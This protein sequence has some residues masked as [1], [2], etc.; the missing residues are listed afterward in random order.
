[1][2][3]GAEVILFIFA[4]IVIAAI[5]W[6][7]NTFGLDWATSATLVRN[8]VI[9]IGIIGS[10]NYF[11]LFKI[12]PHAPTALVGYL[13]C[14]RPAL[15]YWS[16]SQMQN[17]GMFNAEVAWYANGWIQLGVATSI[18]VLGY[19]FIYWINRSRIWY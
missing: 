14:W 18:I 10:L 17:F 7:H 9:F 12:I 19:S 6:F 2:N 11:D 16:N 13:A 4:V 3:Q 8:H 15:E 1:M 5:A